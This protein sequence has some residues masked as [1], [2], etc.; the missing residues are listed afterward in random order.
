MG[1]KNFYAPNGDSITKEEFLDIYNNCYMWNSNIMVENIIEK[2]LYRNFEEK[3]TEED[4]EKIIAWKKGKIKMKSFRY[5]EGEENKFEMAVAKNEITELEYQN[6]ESIRKEDYNN[7]VNKIYESDDWERLLKSLTEIHG[8]GYVIAETLLYFKNPRRYLIY[9]RF[10]Y[11]AVQALV[12]G[13]KP[14]SRIPYREICSLSNMQDL[15]TE[16]YRKMKDIFGE[17]FEGDIVKDIIE[18]RKVDRALWAY[19]HMYLMQ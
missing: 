7:I 2:I 14:W 9:D 13:L 12:N 3:V 17:V 16:Y 11:V 5:V 18:Y 4:I 15:Y 8:V 1:E 19:G 6:G 10:A